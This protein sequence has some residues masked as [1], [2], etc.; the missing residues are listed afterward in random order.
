VLGLSAIVDHA[1]YAWQDA[2]WGP[3]HLP[4][5]VLYEM[6]VGTFSPEGTFDGAAARLGHVVELGV[7]AV[8]VMPVAEFSG[9]HGW[10]YD[11]VDLYAPHRAYGGPEGMKR[12]V[13]ACHAHGLAV[14]VDVVYNHL[15]PA[16][17]FLAEF[18]PYFTDRHKTAWGSAVN[19]DGDGSDEVRRFVV[20]NA[21]MW[22]RDYHADGLRLDAVQ[23]IFDASRRHILSEVGDAVH[24]AGRSLGRRT[25]VVAESN[26]DQVHIVRPRDAG[27]LGLDCVWADDWHH[28][29][30]TVL[31][32]ERLGYYARFGSPDQLATALRGALTRTEQPDVPT[33]VFVVAAQNHD[34]V[35]NRAGGERLS[36]LVDDARQRTA[37]A[38]LL[39]SPFTPMLFQ[40]EEWGACSP[41]L[42]FTDHRDPQLG[43][44]V[45]RGRRSEFAAFGL[46]P[47]AVPDPQDASTF[48]RS[49]LR[50]DEIDE[51]KHRGILAWYRDLIALRRRL[52]PAARDEVKTAVDE[53]LRRITFSRP[54]VEVTVDLRTGSCRV[55][56]DGKPLG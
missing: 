8:E 49:K 6:H 50:W 17:N 5:S 4:G 39:A 45:A 2:G 37:A 12:F 41:F 25:F 31:T 53:R 35:G 34:Q 28:A 44:A 43:A 22:I 32:G 38:L 27:G 24:D 51:P 30:H 48:E 29:L 13:D 18:G 14:I 21:L 1:A 19:F 56:E 16:G 10:G 55:L 42:Y 52:P 23:A 9:D 26:R 15:G 7:D 47:Q 3:P 54:G 11:G 46:E 40:G 20:D 36:M 33:G